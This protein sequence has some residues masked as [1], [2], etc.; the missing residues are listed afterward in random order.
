MPD[1]KGERKESVSCLVLILFVYNYFSDELSEGVR[2]V[3]VR[4]RCLFSNVGANVK[5][6]RQEN[7]SCLDF[8]LFCFND[9]F[10]DTASDHKAT[11]K[12]NTAREQVTFV[13]DN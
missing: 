5:G 11:N 7:V 9:H 3:A 6:K 12:G 8:T 4:I 13:H 10:N 2:C 1:V